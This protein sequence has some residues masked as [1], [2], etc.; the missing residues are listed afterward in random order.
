MIEVDGAIEHNAMMNP[1]SNRMS[2]GSDDRAGLQ[3]LARDIVSRERERDSLFGEVGDLGRLL[4]RLS[5]VTQDVHAPLDA[6]ETVTA[7]GLAISPVKAA[8]CAREPLRTIVFIRGLAAAI[9]QARR[10]DRPVRVLYAGCGPLATL[11][12]PLMTLFDP[13]QASFTLVDIHAASLGSARGLVSRL[14]LEAHVAGYMLA[15]ACSLRLDPAALPDVIVS[16][17]MNAALRSEPQV[18]IMRHLAMQAP[19]ALLVPESVTVEACL[20][21]LGRE[22]SPP[23][24]DGG[25]PQ[26]PRRERV[27]LGPVFRLDA[28][29]IRAWSGLDAALPAG[30]VRVPPTVPAGMQP[31]LLTKIVSFGSHRLQDWESSLNMPQHFPGRPALQGGETL[32]FAYRIGEQ[33]GLV[34]L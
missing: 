1:T 21:R 10:P 8:L 24:D 26:P 33:P 19:Q 2:A 29:A 7:A 3:A 17:T 5:G 28:A 6:N 18:A 13:E 4:E 14:G 9:E 16:E 11:A 27:E 32:Q 34:L 25:A 30:V 22:L 12:L 20:L 23:L 31:R 15:D